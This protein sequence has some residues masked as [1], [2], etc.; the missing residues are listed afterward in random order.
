MCVARLSWWKFPPHVNRNEPI[1][2]RTGSS[3]SRRSGQP[4]FPLAC[5]ISLVWRWIESRMN[6]KKEKKETKE[7]KPLCVRRTEKKEMERKIAHTPPPLASLMSSLQSAVIVDRFRSRVPRIEQRQ[8]RS[9]RF[10]RVCY[11]RG[12]IAE[13]KRRKRIDNQGANQMITSG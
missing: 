8:P 10:I 13:R 6:E 11:T 4:S 5:V 9:Q 7:R 2:R 12:P 1:A 3:S